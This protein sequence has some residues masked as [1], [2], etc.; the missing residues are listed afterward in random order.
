MV[1]ED[2]ERR[3][4][5][6][7]YRLAAMGALLVLTGLR[8]NAGPPPHRREEAPA[9]EVSVAVDAPSPR[10]RRK[11]RIKLRRAQG[12]ALGAIAGAPS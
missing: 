4:L 5:R 6:T 3:W 11:S 12:A 8:T 9:L 10:K 7:V 2:A 1:P